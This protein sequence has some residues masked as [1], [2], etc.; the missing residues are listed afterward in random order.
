MKTVKKVLI[1]F[2][3]YLFF[4]NMAMANN[5][6]PVIKAEDKKLYLSMENVPESTSLMILDGTGS[7]WIEEN[8]TTSKRLE[9]VFNLESL[10]LG[11]YTLIIKSSEEET[12]Q[13]IKITSTGVV[14]EES[15]RAAYFSPVFSQKRGT[16]KL[17]LQNPTN[18]TVRVHIIDVVGRLRYQDSIQGQLAIEKDFNLKQLPAG[19]YN[20]IV[21][22]GHK[23]YTRSI[24]LR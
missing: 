24:N 14:I 3:M 18:S 12:L 2:A 1:S 22:N 6:I 21:N 7:A 15:K 9:R 4:V 23:A 16:L 17:S 20:L 11:A 13:P 19:K 8:V 5:Y 10:P